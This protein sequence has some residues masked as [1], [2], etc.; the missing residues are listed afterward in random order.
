MPGTLYEPR[1]VFSSGNF[2]Y[3]FAGILPVNLPLDPWKRE[4]PEWDASGCSVSFNADVEA[5][6]LGN[7]R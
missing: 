2:P 1:C 4:G 7:Y 5:H 6:F 3:L